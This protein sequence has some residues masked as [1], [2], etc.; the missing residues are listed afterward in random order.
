MD[1]SGMQVVTN[2]LLVEPDG[3][4]IVKRTWKERIFTRPWTPLRPT[5]AVQRFKPSEH[6]YV[7]HGRTIVCHPYVADRIRQAAEKVK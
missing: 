3:F 4:D 6:I 5:K 2:N 1:Y 7:L